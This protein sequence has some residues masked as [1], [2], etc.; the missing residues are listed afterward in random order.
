MPARSAWSTGSLHLDQLDSMNS[1]PFQEP[2][3]R[4][5][6]EIAG[7]HNGCPRICDLEIGK[8]DRDCWHPRPRYPDVVT[9]SDGPLAQ[10]RAESLPRQ[11]AAS[12]SR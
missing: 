10:L 8:V 7:E 1:K 6:V 5:L 4:R 12:L 11:P 9:H 2:V 3:Q